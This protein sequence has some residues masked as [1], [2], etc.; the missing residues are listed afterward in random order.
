MKERSSL[1]KLTSEIV[2]QNLNS[3]NNELKLID[4]FS[5][6]FFDFSFFLDEILS[7]P[8]MCR[9]TI[10][11]VLSSSVFCTQ[12]YILLFLFSAKGAGQQCCY[13]NFGNL[14]MGKPNAGS[15]DRVHPNA[16]L[17]VISHF[18]HDL[19]PYQDCCRLSDSCEKYYEKRPSDDGSKYQAPRPGM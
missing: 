17:P 15:L 12:C 11:F 14:M 4:L 19:V 3:P 9:L 7:S 16:G 6:H 18:F 2:F 1:K 8:F 5:F 13:N 10:V